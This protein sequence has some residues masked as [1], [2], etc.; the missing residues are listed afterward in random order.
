MTGTSVTGPQ[1][2]AGGESILAGAE[3]EPAE[4]EIGGIP[5]D[6]HSRVFCEV[7]R[8]DFEEVWGAG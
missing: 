5:L 8:F 3:S 6:F 1:E 7:C 2:V 4:G